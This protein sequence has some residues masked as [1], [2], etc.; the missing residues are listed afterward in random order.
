[1]MLCITN[2]SKIIFSPKKKKTFKIIFALW[3]L[4]K[5]VILLIYLE[6]KGRNQSN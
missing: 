4:F 5:W 2:T 3:K 6:D 1:M